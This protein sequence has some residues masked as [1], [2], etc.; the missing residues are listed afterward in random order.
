MTNPV[1]VE[2]TRGPLVESV[3][4]GTVAVVDAGGG[5]RL[6]LGNIERAIFPRSALKPVQAVPLIESGAAD[7]FAGRSAATDDGASGSASE[8]RRDHNHLEQQFHRGHE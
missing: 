5:L 3:H 7:A 8:Q 6:A 4:R 1:L 2:V